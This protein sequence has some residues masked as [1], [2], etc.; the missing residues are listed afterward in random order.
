MVHLLRC[1]N[2]ETTPSK[3]KCTNHWQQLN[4]FIKQLSVNLVP[5][6]SDLEYSAHTDYFYAAFYQFGILVVQS[7]LTFIIF[8][9]WTGYS[10]NYATFVYW[11]ND[12]RIFLVNCPFKKPIIAHL[13]TS[14]CALGLT[15]GRVYG[16][17]NWSLSGCLLWILVMTPSLMGNQSMLGTRSWLGSKQ[18]SSIN[19]SSGSCGWLSSRA[20]NKTEK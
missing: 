20:I 4:L 8:K 19:V 6:K 10:S 18:H 13:N 1:W 7:L 12:D 5:Q 17:P 14:T 15:P 2:P 11:L 3:H 9:K 16:L